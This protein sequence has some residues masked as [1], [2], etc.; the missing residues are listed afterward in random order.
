MTTNCDA[1]EITSV[2]QG[3]VLSFLSKAE[4]GM[5]R[6]DTH[7]SVVF[8][9]KD[10][11]LKIKRAVRLPFLD[12][13]TLDRRRSACEEELFVNRPY[14]PQLYRR[15]V[16]IT[17][18]PVGLAIDGSGEPV[19]WAVEMSRFDETRGFDR[20][21]T[22]EEI[23]HERAIALADAIL[24]AHSRQPPVRNSGWIDSIAGILKQSTVRFRTVDGL[25]ASDVDHLDARSHTELIAHRRLL[26]S[27]AE[28]GF[29]RR[30]HGDLHLGNIVLIDGRPVLFD[31]IEFDPAIATTD[32]LYDLAFPLMDLIRYGS[33]IAANA[34]FNRYIN[35]SADANRS[36][37][38][39]L[40]L[41][42]SMRAAIRASV[43]FTK[44]EQN[45]KDRKPGWDEAKRYFDL[46]IELID[47][48]PPRMVAIGGL[49]GTGKSVLARAIAPTLAPPP[50]ALVLRSD[51][52]R[53]KLFG[54]AETERL[55]ASA[56][57]SEVTARVY[58]A[59]LDGAKLV[60][61]Q[62]CSVVLDAA[63]LQSGERASFAAIAPAAIPRT[64]VFLTAERAVRLA[65]IAQRT[66]DASD[67]T[68]AVAIQ[69]EDMKLGAI[70][71]TLINAGGTA[72]QTLALARG[73]LDVQDTPE[74]CKT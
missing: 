31:A 43:L 29:V 25:A 47:P 70:D 9:G 12:Y 67:A 28:T 58:D 46:A 40:P 45:E 17:R 72:E 50:G 48:A 13:S 49:S 61:T 30:C 73:H 18:E 16:P 14:A 2:D 55:P 53:K 64:G 36:A 42:L 24:A 10:R 65:R 27:R 11:V 35:K 74:G 44:S 69:Q 51:V 21:A 57:T 22:H 60:A 63:F 71:W 59:L 5:Q 26:L 15:V 68:A 1:G 66:N 3:A 41:F 39:L 32:I 56:Y 62:G 54:V 4:P 38:A 6:V 7:A 8:L 19:E 52:I 20:L 34:L 37:L 33:T 23:G